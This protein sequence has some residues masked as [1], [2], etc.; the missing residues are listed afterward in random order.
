[1]AAEPHRRQSYDQPRA[2]ARLAVFV[3]IGD[4]Y[5]SLLDGVG[6]VRLKQWVCH[7]CRRGCRDSLAVGV[8]L[9]YDVLVLLRGVGVRC[10][11]VWLVKAHVA[12]FGASSANRYSNILPNIRMR[13]TLL[14]ITTR[15]LAD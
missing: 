1:M 15:T 4:H 9:G 14:A 11:N 12:H 10:L 13:T 5:P 2:I 6:L 7:L 8:R 3:I